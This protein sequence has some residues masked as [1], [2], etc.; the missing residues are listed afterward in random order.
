MSQVLYHHFGTFRLAGPR[1]PADQDALVRPGLAEILECMLRRPEY[2]GISA[3]RRSFVRIFG[4]IL[5][6]DKKY[7]SIIVEMS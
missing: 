1:F 2:V 4:M 7:A 5:K 3:W 6:R